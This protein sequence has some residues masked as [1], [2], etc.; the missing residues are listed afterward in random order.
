[1][2]EIRQEERQRNEKAAGSRP[3]RPWLRPVLVAAAAAAIVGGVLVALPSGADRTTATPA[4]AP[5]EAARLLEDIA[6]AAAKR[7][8]PDDI[9]DDQYVYVKSRV[10]YSA[11]GLKADKPELEPLHDRE[12]W[13]AVDGKRPG[14]LVEKNRNGR[15]EL[16]PDAPGDTT[17]T[18]YRRLQTLPTDPDAM[19]KW[20]YK[21]KQGDN[22]KHEQAFTFV[23][24]LSRESLLP[25][26]QAAALYRAAAKLPGVEVVKGVKDAAGRSGI[27]VSRADEDGFDRQLIFNPKTLEYQGE[28]VVAARD[29]QDGLEKGDLAGTAAILEREVVDKVEQ[30]P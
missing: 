10:G 29:T 19:L 1:M 5:G 3:G 30:R 14:L 28:R 22:P 4:P 16:G 13:H 2:T 12:V 25:P 17:A 15:E 6:L 11:W 23:G 26:A 20:L 7:D 27:G 8:V 9:R 18:N 21:N 24:D